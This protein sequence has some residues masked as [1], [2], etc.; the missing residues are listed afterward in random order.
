M[1]TATMS[2]STAPQHPWAATGQRSLHPADEAEAKLLS[3]RAKAAKP[4]T[5]EWSRTRCVGEW[6]THLSP[7]LMLT[8]L[9]TMVSARL[10]GGA[11][12]W[13]DLAVFG[14]LF[15]WQPF[16]EWIIHTHM[17]HLKP[18]PFGPASWGLRFDLPTARRHRQVYS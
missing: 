4:F 14:L 5:G 16:N 15:A 13:A 2:N 7:L 10:C 1:S 12:Q 11:L 9:V 6:L 18:R 17:L 8:G 3:D